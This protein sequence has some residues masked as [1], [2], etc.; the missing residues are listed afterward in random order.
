MLTRKMLNLIKEYL[1][2][3]IN[4]ISNYLF[5]VISL[6]EKHSFKIYIKLIKLI[7]KCL[8]F[9]HINLKQINEYFSKKYLEKKIFFYNDREKKFSFFIKQDTLREEFQKVEQRRIDFTLST[10]KA[11]KNFT[12]PNKWTELFL[13]GT[14]NPVS[15]EELQLKLKKF[16][17]WWWK[18]IVNYSYL[19]LKTRIIGPLKNTSRKAWVARK[20]FLDK[21]LWVL[22]KFYKVA[23]IIVIIIIFFI[24][25]NLIFLHYYILMYF[26]VN[27]LF[28]FCD[29]QHL[30][31]YEFFFCQVEYKS[32][33]QRCLE[34][35][36]Y[37]IIV[38]PCK[39]IWYYLDLILN[40]TDIYDEYEYEI[41]TKITNEVMNTT[42]DNDL[43][44][45]NSLRER[46][47]SKYYQMD[48]R[49]DYRVPFEFPKQK[50]WFFF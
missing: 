33:T 46:R 19:F 42:D 13:I 1:K 34:F 16:F 41:Q 25:A 26:T 11:T 8:V 20:T 5:K 9:L 27:I 12:Y 39:F 28:I 21:I 50:K 14:V 40:G 2:K 4:L 10:D 43:E 36:F 3:I 35:V 18:E 30:E 6:I 32:L 37:Y 44:F 29:Y 38:P 23:R 17:E 48:E 45:I 49:Y 31:I 15:D 47:Y 24:D 22:E 7:K